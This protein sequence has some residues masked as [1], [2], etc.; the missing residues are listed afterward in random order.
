MSDGDL[1]LTIRGREGPIR[2]R[3]DPCRP[4]ETERGAVAALSVKKFSFNSLAFLS[5]VVVTIR[6]R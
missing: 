3:R 6:D 4:R 5:V 2:S 1:E